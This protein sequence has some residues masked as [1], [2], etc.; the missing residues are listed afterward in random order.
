MKFQNLAFLPQPQ[1]L[2]APESL[3]V[4]KKILWLIQAKK[5][6]CLE[7][8]FQG[9][10]VNTILCIQNKQGNKVNKLSIAF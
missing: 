9:T 2:Y 4:K 8:R 10:F 6:S 3:D 7:N 1:R 5:P